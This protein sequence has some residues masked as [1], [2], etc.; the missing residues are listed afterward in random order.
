MS[1]AP[2]RR[3]AEAAS[4]WLHHEYL[5][6]RAGLFDEAA[7]KFVIGQ[8][9]SSFPSDKPA[10][11][12]SGVDH[13]VLAD[14]ATNRKPEIDF[15]LCD[16]AGNDRGDI[17]VAVEVKWADSGHCTPRNIMSDVWRLCVLAGYLKD[18]QVDADCILVIAGTKGKIKEMIRKR[19][20]IGLGSLPT[21]SGRQ[22]IIY[23]EVFGAG[24]KDGWRD[25]FMANKNKDKA[26]R[27]A[28][29]FI[30]VPKIGV[31]FHAGIPAIN[32]TGDSTRSS[33]SAVKFHAMAW[34]IQ[35][36]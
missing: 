8:V 22:K 13:P 18:K 25:L 21:A 35:S 14:Y 28:Y 16:L 29:D 23:P 9:L 5:C 32:L 33:D 17:R 26:M 3:L 34:S 27:E 7:L 1:I 2:A 31:T 20:F 4:C 6:L 11:V 24:G 15:A 12:W 19:P 10:R 36:L 30:S